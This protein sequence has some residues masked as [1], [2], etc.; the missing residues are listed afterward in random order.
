M[1]DAGHHGPQNYIICLNVVSPRLKQYFSYITSCFEYI[2]CTFCIIYPDTKTWNVNATPIT[3]SA[4]EGSHYYHFNYFVWHCRWSNFSF[5]HTV[6]NRFIQY[7]F[8]HSWIS[9][10]S[11]TESLQHYL[12]KICCMR[13]R[14]KCF[15]FTGT[16]I[17]WKLGASDLRVK[18]NDR[19]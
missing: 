16:E 19:G 7:L 12:L 18:R 13:E 8:F 9:S 6:F 4:K 2:S 14:V 10:I 5:C 3:L 15:H 17:G 11:L 1:S